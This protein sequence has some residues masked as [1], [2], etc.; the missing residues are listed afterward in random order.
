MAAFRIEAYVTHAKYG[1]NRIPDIWS[2]LQL[3]RMNSA[4]AN[5]KHTM[6][7]SAVTGLFSAKNAGDH[8]KLR[9]N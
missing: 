3:R 8:K 1:T 4:I 9:T 5:N 6:M 7:T 2:A